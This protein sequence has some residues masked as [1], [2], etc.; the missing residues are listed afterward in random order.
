MR[1]ILFFILLMVLARP[2]HAQFDYGFDFSKTATAGFQFLKIGVGAREAALGKAASSLTRDANAV[3]WNVGALPLIEGNQ[4]YLTH[5]SWLAGSSLD[6]AV[7]AVPLEPYVVALSVMQFSIQEFEETTV[8][9]PGGTGRMVSAGDLMVGLAVARRFT[10]RLTIGVQIKYVRESLDRDAFNN[11]L[12]DVGTVYYTGL[13]NLRL[14]FTLQHFGPDLRGLDHRF[15]M[16]L[17]FRVSAADDLVTSDLFQLRTAV[18]LVH[19]TDNDEWVNWGVEAVL[20]R[21]LALRAGY[22]FNV[23][24][25]GWSLGAGVRSPSFAGIGLVFDYAYVPF[26]D[27]FGATHRFTLGIDM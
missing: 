8:V 13:H 19:P 18:E 2:A 26:G 6:A 24:R 16:P 22:R 21:M 12:F 9:Q 17:L 5:S 11:V 1:R 15:R 23:D 4:A 10:D 20:A 3:F 27:I 7:A 25:A 14:A